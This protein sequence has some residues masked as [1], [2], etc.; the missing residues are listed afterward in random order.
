MLD[1]YGWAT[2]NS[3]RVS[4]L[5]EELGLDYAVHPVNIRKAE[6]FRHEV[7]ALNPYGKVPIVVDRDPSLVAPVVL[8]ESGAI[9]IYLAERSGRFLPVEPS[10]R[11]EV[12]RW[13]MVALTSLGPFMGQAHHWTA[14][15][16][17]RLPSAMDH[18]VALAARVFAVLDRHLAGRTWVANDYSIADIAVFPWVA[19][20]DWANQELARY[21]A[22]AAWHDRVAARPAVQRGMRVPEGARLE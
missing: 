3:N 15:A 19:R 22:L 17:E 2:P 10:A 21:P 8:F 5:L 7:L 16:K 14:L 9:L 13:S 11:A 12:L 20:S 6:Q 1:F 18:S 4:I